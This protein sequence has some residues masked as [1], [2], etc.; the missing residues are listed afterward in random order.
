[1]PI[2][3]FYENRNKNTNFKAYDINVIR[4]GLQQGK[5]N[6]TGFNPSKT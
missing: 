2:N 5:V 3:S 1:M 6:R 4:K